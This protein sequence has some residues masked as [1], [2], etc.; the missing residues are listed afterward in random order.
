MDSEQ[1]VAKGKAATRLLDDP[2][3]REALESIKRKQ[4]DAFASSSL[5]KREV[6]ESAYMMLKAVEDLELQLAKVKSDGI[7]E[8]DRA[9][10]KR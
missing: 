1:A 2:V 8:E 9:K 4:H 5:E 10:R 3:L 7:F 6:R